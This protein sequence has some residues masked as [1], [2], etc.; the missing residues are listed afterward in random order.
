MLG[1]MDASD[2]LIPAALWLRVSTE[3]Q[4]RENQ[5][6]AL[7]QFAAH[8][9]YRIAVTYELDDSAWN[10]G[11]DNGLYRRTLKR[12][13]DEA[14]QGAYKVL[15]V[16]AL[17]RSLTGKRAFRATLACVWLVL[18]TSLTLAY[19]ANDRIDAGSLRATAALVPVLAVALSLGEWAHHR[20]DE[21]RFRVFVY[22]LLLG[23]GV[24][25]LL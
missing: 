21:R 11:K 20:L 19:T 12:A 23:A 6:P 3:E 8:H 15:V 16:W 14:H 5:L 7:Q 10:G 1:P 25:S 13:L 22:V 17:G 2:S 24:S 9:G 18:A 4:E